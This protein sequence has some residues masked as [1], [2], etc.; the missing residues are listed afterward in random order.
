MRGTR[1]LNF[2]TFFILPGDQDQ[3]TAVLRRKCNQCAARQVSSTG[4]AVTANM[5]AASGKSVRMVGATVYPDLTDQ[6]TYKMLAGT[7]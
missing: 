3:T 5:L 2:S 6:L 4:S 1:N 7:H